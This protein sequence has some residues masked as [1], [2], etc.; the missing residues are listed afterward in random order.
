MFEHSA[1]PQM[2]LVCVLET[3][4]AHTASPYWFLSTSPVLWYWVPYIMAPLLSSFVPSS[5][6]SW[7][8]HTVLAP[9]PEWLELPEAA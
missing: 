8:R 1:R 9:D 6:G 2:V 7:C 5:V 3:H 4:T